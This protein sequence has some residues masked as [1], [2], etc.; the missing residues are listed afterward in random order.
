M[1]YTKWK[2]FKR[3][4]LWYVVGPGLSGVTIPFETHQA[5]LNYIA[6]V[7]DAFAVF[8]KA[9]PQADNFWILREL[10]KP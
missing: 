7:L 3:G 6:P 5:A 9:K 1:P 2:I 4:D 8:E 10:I